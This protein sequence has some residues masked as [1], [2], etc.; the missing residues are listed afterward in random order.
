METFLS[1]AQKF[2]VADLF[3]IEYVTLDLFKYDFS[4]SP[5]LVSS[6]LSMFDSHTDGGESFDVFSL[7][8]LCPLFGLLGKLHCLV[9][10][11]IYMQLCARKS[12]VGYEIFYEYKIT[13][14]N[15]PS[16]PGLQPADKLL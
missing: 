9:D 11:H 15:D 10:D 4:L 16:T 2:H 1:K 7:E 5:N 8:E 12:R 14:L 3:D 13:Q 6:L